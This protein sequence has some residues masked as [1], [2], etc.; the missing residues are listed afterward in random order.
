[1]C[2]KSVDILCRLSAMHERDRQTEKQTDHGTVTSIAIG[3][4]KSSLLTR[5]LNHNTSE[6]I[7]QLTSQ[8][9]MIKRDCGLFCYDDIELE[10]SSVLILIV[11]SLVVTGSGL[12]IFSLVTSR[13]DI[14]AISR[15]SK[16]G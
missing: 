14:N 6:V 4:I 3:E 8:S 16:I 12:L 9:R 11:V 1:V 15:L 5:F 10:A 13:D 7:F 2:K